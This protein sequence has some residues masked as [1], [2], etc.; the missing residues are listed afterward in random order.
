MIGKEGLTFAT[1]CD[2]IRMTAIDS[3]SLSSVP[4][5]MTPLFG[6]RASSGACHDEVQLSE[7]L[8]FFFWENYNVL[9]PEK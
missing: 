6:R 2:T 7:R 9:C 8:G 5:P 3:E 4:N 1:A